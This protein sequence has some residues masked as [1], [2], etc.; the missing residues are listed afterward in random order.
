MS[1]L[2]DDAKQQMKK[3]VEATKNV[4]MG[5]RTGRANP[6]LLNGI[7]V[8]YYGAQTPL[9]QIATITVPDP[10]QLSVTPFDASQI[11]AVEK[12]IRDSDLGVNPQ[13]DGMMLRINLPAMTEE[14]RREYVKLAREK[15]EEGKISLRNIRRKAREELDKE[16]KDSNISED[17]YSREL[18]ALDTLTKSFSEEIDVLLETKEADILEV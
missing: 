12:A 18:K 3:T 1:Q 10:R 6:A 16:K 15:A 9:K 8:E 13:R 7:T 11:A 2:N 17:E 14:R 5:I 4:F